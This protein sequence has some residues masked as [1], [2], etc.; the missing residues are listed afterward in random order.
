MEVFLAIIHGFIPILLVG[1]P[2]NG[3]LTWKL[4][5]GMVGARH[6]GHSRCVDPGTQ[7]RDG[8]NPS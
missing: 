2:L 4:N 1:I 6:K 3:V 8:G 5:T 7:Q